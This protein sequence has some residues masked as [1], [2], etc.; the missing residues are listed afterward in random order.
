MPELSADQREL[1]ISGMCSE[2]FDA[3]FKEARMKALNE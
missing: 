1:L 3:L 2:C